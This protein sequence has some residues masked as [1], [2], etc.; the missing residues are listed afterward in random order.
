MEHIAVKCEPE[1]WNATVSFAAIV[2]IFLGAL[3]ICTRG[4][5]ILF[6]AYT[7]RWFGTV[8]KTQARTRVLGTVVTM[9]ALLMVWAGM[10]QRAGLEAVL[11]V[12]GIFI[13]VIAVPGLLLFP[14]IYMNLANSLMP[15]D[16]S[17]TLFGW[18]LLGLL[19][20]IIGVA[21]MMVGVNAL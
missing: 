10:S 17:G 7:F 9:I 16:L 21:I 18:R 4:P 20:V 1:S 13:L 5:L 3:I 19:G 11:F 6:P 8:I 14:S 2:A 15:D 12:F